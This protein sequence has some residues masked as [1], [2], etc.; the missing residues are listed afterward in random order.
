MQETI[1]IDGHVHLYPQFDIPR[2]I[3]YSLHNFI[4]SQRTSANR[5]DAIKFWFLVEA[6][7][8]SYFDNLV[9]MK[10]DRYSVEQTDEKE[11]LVVK[12]S[13]TGEPLLR[14][15]AGRQIVTKENLEVCALLSN[16]K[17]EDKSLTTRE[18]LTVLHD[19]HAIA[20]LNWAPG[21]WFGKRGKIVL[22]LLNTHSPHQ[23]F[24]SDTT[25]RPTVWPTPKL[26]QKAV[27]KGFRIIRGS[28]P[29]PFKDEEKNI[30]CYAFLVQGDFNYEKPGSSLREILNNPQTD[31]TPCG[32]RSGP[33][34][35]TKRQRKIMAHKTKKNQ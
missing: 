21:K 20:A 11:I 12:D 2:A 10:L 34:V 9:K 32:K 22:D 6:Q 28:D 17:I 31:F 35:F 7:N 23:F 24:I 27:T 16:E 25:M 30:G 19:S 4:N 1:L 3:Q 18:T 13:G 29:L 33:F 14:I 8:Y 15:A 26:V 5:D